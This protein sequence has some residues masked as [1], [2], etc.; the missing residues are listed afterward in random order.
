VVVSNLPSQFKSSSKICG[1]IFTVICNGIK[2]LW[3]I[4][5]GLVQYLETT[6]STQR[7]DLGDQEQATDRESN[8][9]AISF[10]DTFNCSFS[11]A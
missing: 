11:Y 3:C 10:K 8:L 2:V 4:H 7:R 9:I 1:K 6:S 5:G